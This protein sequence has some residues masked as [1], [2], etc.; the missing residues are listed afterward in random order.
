MRGL[1]ADR[2]WATNSIGRVPCSQRG[3]Y[4]FKSSVAHH[5]RVGWSG[6]ALIDADRL[7]REETSE[8][9]DVHAGAEETENEALCE[10]VGWAEVASEGLRDRTGNFHA[11]S[12]AVA[13]SLLGYGLAGPPASRPG[14][15]ET[16]A[17]PSLIPRWRAEPTTR[18]T[19]R[20]GL[21]KP[22]HNCDGPSYPTAIAA[23]LPFLPP[24]GMSPMCWA[25][26]EEL[27]PLLFAVWSR[28][29]ILLPSTPN[30]GS[31]AVAA[32]LT[33]RMPSQRWT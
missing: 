27:R 20:T 8:S 17:D 5:Q 26:P 32:T 15:C 11:T 30:S 31:K 2:T 12:V 9:V 33:R 29:I 28:E 18:L 19:W 25:H 16:F 4:W 23:L 7:V 14:S 10:E 21:G 1:R 24:P 3:S 13:G 6:V 22:L